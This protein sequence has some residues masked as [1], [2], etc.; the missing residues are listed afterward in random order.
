MQ[1]RFGLRWF[2]AAIAG[3]CALTALPTAAAQSEA[4][5][6]EGQR[7][8]FGELFEGSWCEGPTILEEGERRQIGGV[9]LE[10]QG[11]ELIVTGGV[12]NSPADRRARPFQPRAIPLPE[13]GAETPV[14]RL[15]AH[16]IQRG[17][18]LEIGGRHGVGIGVLRIERDWRGVVFGPI[19]GWEF[20]L[21]EHRLAVIDRDLDGI[22]S[23]RD[24]M[25]Y[26][27]RRLW[28]PWHTVTA[29]GAALYERILPGG[30]GSITLISRP[31]A[32]PG[33]DAA[34]WAD[35][36]RERKDHGIPP[37]VFSEVLQRHAVLH[38]DYLRRH[39]LRTHDQDPAL[40]GH[41]PEGRRAGLSSCISYQGRAGA[42]REFLDS[43]Y[44]R[45]QIIDP[46]DVVLGLG[47]NAYAFLMGF[48]ED[49]ALPAE[50]RALER[51]QLHPAPGA[52]VPRGTYS[53]EDPQHPILERSR[54]PGL[55]VIVRVAPYEPTFEDVQASLYRVQGRI[56]DGQR[57]GEVAV[58]VS[59]SGHEAPEEA[60][61]LWGMVAMTPFQPLP[62]GTYEADV[63]FR[64]EGEE[65]HYRWRFRVG[66]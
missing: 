1:Q 9:S 28:M 45:P 26:D 18:D 51:P 38:A 23:T 12:L 27:R 24:R 53:P 2:L 57:R 36:Q 17:I 58:H 16:Q 5:R 4:T 60:P 8:V 65:H 34:V 55:P 49:P 33:A 25:V 63:R 6:L 50:T 44:H 30:D 66:R 62:V 59:Y 31:M 14:L 40:E 35:W 37:G 20:D 22:L 15:R 13:R 32:S 10:L 7:W 39:R 19:S 3:L 61:Y 48:G 56:A 21:G 64:L 54:Q 42:L 29:L 52:S 47:G 46:R 43:L 11:G 41:T